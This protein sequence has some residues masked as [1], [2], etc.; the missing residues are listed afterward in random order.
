MSRKRH[1]IV[2]TAAMATVTWAATCGDG[3]TEPPAP[4]PDPPRPTT[5]TVNPATTELNALGATEQ[6]TAEVRDQNGQVMAGAAVTWASSAAAVATVSNA[7][8]RPTAASP[9]PTPSRAATLP[10]P[11]PCSPRTE[12]SFRELVGVVRGREDLV[13][14]WR[15]DLDRRHKGERA[16]LGKARRQRPADR[17]EGARGLPKG[18]AERG[19]ARRGAEGRPRRPSSTGTPSGRAVGA[20]PAFLPACPRPEAPSVAGEGSSDDP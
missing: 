7:H 3:A 14:S 15:E 2:L 1:F 12:P 5:V 9:R 11:P 13:E 4:P 20:Y 6:L 17:A 18:A 10:T 19:A 8:P 16:A